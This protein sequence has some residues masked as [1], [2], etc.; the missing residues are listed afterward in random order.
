MTPTA[1]TT[2]D[3]PIGKIA[4]HPRNPRREVG[5][6]TDLAASIA[7]VGILQDLV[8]APWPSDLDS[9]APRGTEYVLIAGHRR[10]TAA[11]LAKLK[12]VPARVRTDLDTVRA[13][14]EA[15]LVENLHRTDLTPV[16]EADTYQALLDLPGLTQTALAKEVGYPVGRIRDRLKLARL[17]QA[18]KDKVH[19]GQLT[20]T[21]AIAIGEFKDD[22]DTVADLIGHVGSDRFGWQLQR[23]VQDRKNAAAAQ[24]R[25]QPF[26]DAGFPIEKCS[27]YSTPKAWKPISDLIDGVP[28]RYQ[29]TAD[30]VDA[31]V[32]NLHSDCP[33]RTVGYQAPST[34]EHYCAE[35]KLHPQHR[36]TKS[37]AELD[38]ALADRQRKAQFN[39]NSQVATALRRQFISEALAAG[40]ADDVV[41][42]ALERRVLDVEPWLAKKDRLARWQT[43]SHLVGGNSTPPIGEDDAEPWLASIVSRLSINALLLL[44]EIRTQEPDLARKDELL[45]YQVPTDYV[46]TLNDR[47]AYPWTDWERETFLVDKVLAGE[48]F[49]PDDD[50]EDDDDDSDEDAAA[51]DAQDGEQS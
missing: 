46:R 22:P 32:L 27:L 18:V 30:E 31:A 47:L 45:P 9:K 7:A 11:R 40:P 51:A 13:Q 35:P 17:D 34:I 12:T 1:S 6:V 25:L 15:A 10:I 20:I 36:P 16:E 14:L 50:E 43:I 38:E 42:A 41:R 5:D 23:A 37:Q 39:D 49:D 2:L 19:T 8:I 3:V 4:L 21:D 48:D 33:G 44:D 24:K 29:A 28:Q 26:R